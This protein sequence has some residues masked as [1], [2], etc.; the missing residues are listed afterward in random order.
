LLS[1]EPARLLFLLSFW[2]ICRHL[3]HL[4]LAWADVCTVKRVYGVK[5]SATIQLSSRDEF[6]GR[7]ISDFRSWKGA[8]KNHFLFFRIQLS[9]T[10]DH[11]LDFRGAQ[12]GDGKHKPPTEYF[13]CFFGLLRHLGPHDGLFVGYF[14]SL[15]GSTRLKSPPDVDDTAKPDT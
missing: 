1:T 8:Y 4:F 7:F 15:S 11:P 13:F 14:Q 12:N 6:R 10:N 9:G 3:T 5:S 2:Q